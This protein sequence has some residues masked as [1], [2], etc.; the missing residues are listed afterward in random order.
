MIRLIV[1]G[2]PFEPLL[3]SCPLVFSVSRMNSLFLLFII[4]IHVASRLSVPESI[5]FARQSVYKRIYMSRVS[6]NLLTF[7]HSIIP[8]SST[9]ILPDRRSLYGIYLTLSRWQNCLGMENPLDIIYFKSRTAFEKIKLLRSCYEHSF[10]F[11]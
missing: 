11:V 9:W 8:S 6:T 10:S 4:Y 5:A 7:F 3:V 2:F 1:S